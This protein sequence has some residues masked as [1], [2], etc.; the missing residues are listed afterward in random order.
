LD[1]EVSSRCRSLLGLRIAQA[2]KFYVVTDDQSL[3]K[4]ALIELCK[5]AY[6]VD[7]SGFDI[8]RHKISNKASKFALSVSG[9]SS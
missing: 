6:E 1:R 3:K 5:K 2:V 7:N 4:E 9:A 8:E